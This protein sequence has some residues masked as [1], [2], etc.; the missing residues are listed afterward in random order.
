ML[1]ALGY[2]GYPLAQFLARTSAHAAR[3]H[4]GWVARRVRDLK[5]RMD[6][7]MPA[8]FI[9]WDPESRAS[10][11]DLLESPRQGEFLILHADGSRG[12]SFVEAE[13]L[14][15]RLRLPTGPAR[16][17]RHVGLPLVPVF[18]VTR[19]DGRHDIVV[20]AP[21][22][23]EGSIEEATLRCAALL[24]GH[25]RRRP[26]LWWTWDRLRC[27][28]DPLGTLRLTAR[29]AATPPDLFVRGGGAPEEETPRPGRARPSRPPSPPRGGTLAGL[30]CL[31]ATAAA[32]LLL[33][34]TRPAPEPSLAGTPLAAALS[35]S[36]R[37]AELVLPSPDGVRVRAV[38]MAP[39][40][41]GPFPTLVLNHGGFRGLTPDFLEYAERWREAGFAVAASEYRGQGGSEGRRE[42]AAGEVDDV[43]TLL[44]WVRA[45]PETDPERV[46]FLGMSHGGTITLLAL[47]RSAPV[48][49]AVV[50]SAVSDAQDMLERE[51]ARALLL[52]RSVEFDTD[53]PAE[54]RRRDAF[55]RI[56][57]VHVPV[58]V[59]H[60]EEDPIVPVGQARRLAEALRAAGVK[61]EIRIFPGAGHNLKGLPEAFEEARRFLARQLALPE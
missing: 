18:C 21:V 34:A 50:Q 41:E 54:V 24:E 4:G 32:V 11:R 3:E 43:L 6:E 49:A 52:R 15:A 30:L 28:R 35:R 5:V 36:L 37:G 26:D 16:V 22:P 48:R 42:F 7:R 61:T 29:A 17:A 59:L 47:A 44:R 10:L 19:E 40:G 60:G 55:S 27:E 33:Q 9:H 2:E 57:Q 38:W 51:H 13:F 20:E 31:A 46:A 56:A 23:A 8:R 45:Q 58:L 53:D 39:E 14:G 1:A 25:V 12:T